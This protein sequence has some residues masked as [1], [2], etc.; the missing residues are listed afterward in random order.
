[1]TRLWFYDEGNRADMK[2]GDTNTIIY[3]LYKKRILMPKTLLNNETVFR[4]I[5]KCDFCIVFPS[6]CK[7]KVLLKKNNH[8]EGQAKNFTLIS[9]NAI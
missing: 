8:S 5:C 3:I 9:I 1:M 2:S 4:T 6:F 7:L